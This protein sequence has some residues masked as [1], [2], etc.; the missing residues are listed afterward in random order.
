MRRSIDVIAT[1]AIANQ[2]GVGK[3]W[4]ERDRNRRRRRYNDT[5]VQKK[6]AFGAEA[7]SH[8]EPDAAL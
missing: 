7:R 4:D 5:T 2:V 1:Y 3:I 6:G 8:G